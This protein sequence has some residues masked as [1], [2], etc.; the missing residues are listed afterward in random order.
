MFN[1]NSRHHVLTQNYYMKKT[2]QASL[3][4]RFLFNAWLIWSHVRRPNCYEQLK[5]YWEMKSHL[6][7]LQ[8][9]L[10]VCYETWTSSRQMNAGSSRHSFGEEDKL[11]SRHNY[12]S[13]CSHSEKR[14][15]FETKSRKKSSRQLKEQENTRWQN[16]LKFSPTKPAIVLPC[17]WERDGWF[18]DVDHI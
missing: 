6:S 5:M 2:V 8:D 3:L 4:Y 7:A 12:R 13:G 11:L 17:F 16:S 14:I 9:I 10:P 18:C 1:I 15:V